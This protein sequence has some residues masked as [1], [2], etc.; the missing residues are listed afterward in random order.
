[1]NTLKNNK[2]FFKLSY[3][4]AVYTD[5]SKSLLEAWLDV[6]NL[7]EIAFTDEIH[8]HARVIFEKF[9]QCHTCGSGTDQEVNDNEE[10]EREAYKE[11]LIIIGFLGR[12]STSHSMNQLALHME[13]KLNEL[14]TSLD[15]PD[16]GN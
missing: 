2:Q 13:A 15:N 9:I 1:L 12:L 7:A 8:H 11:Q 5:A 14:C 6:I 10:S 3:G 4:D 16:N